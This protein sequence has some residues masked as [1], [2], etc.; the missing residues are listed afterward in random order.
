MSYFKV[1]CMTEGFA[2]TC[3]HKGLT[4]VIALTD[5]AAAEK[6]IEQKKSYF[7]SKGLTAEAI[8]GGFKV[9][10]A[11]DFSFS[12]WAEKATTWEVIKHKILRR[13][14]AQTGEQIQDW[15]YGRTH[16]PEYYTAE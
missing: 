4:N 6:L 2:L 5:Q 12:F 15:E 9:K 7:T 8:P 16:H 14:F 1:F 11:E 3:H 13:P 10:T